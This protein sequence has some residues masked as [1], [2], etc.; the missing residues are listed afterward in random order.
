ME[1]EP[2]SVQSVIHLLKELDLTSSFEVYIPSLKQNVKFKQLNTEQFKRLLK[3]VVDSPIYNT[4]FITTFNSIIKENCLEKEIDVLNFNILDKL[5]I[6][7]KLRIE[8]V[9]SNFTFNFTKDEINENNL[10]QETYSVNLA[11]RYDTFVQQAIDVL[12]EVYQHD[13]IYLTCSLPTIATEN[14]LEKELHKNIKLEITTPEELR[15]TIGDTFINELSKYINSLKIGETEINLEQLTFKDRVKIIEQLP[16][17]AIN[18][19][20]KYIEKYKKTIAPL[21]IYKVLNTQF[22][23]EIPQDA[24]F[25]NI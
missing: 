2:T 13:S 16:T 6:F 24:T 12:P 11:E 10:T 4:E 9:D 23:K 15:A 22:E 17:T 5:L 3:S 18:Q 20:L 7:I 14:K 21:T 8:S 1:K 25:F 19:T